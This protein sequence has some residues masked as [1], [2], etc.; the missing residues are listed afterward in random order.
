M[1]H[2]F[3]EGVSVMA[4]V[5]AFGLLCHAIFALSPASLVLGLAAALFAAAADSLSELV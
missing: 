2:E 4:L 5:M 3:L 1:L